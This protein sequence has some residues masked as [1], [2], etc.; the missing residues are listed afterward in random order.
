MC[1]AAAIAGSAVVGA[2]ASA[3]SA[4]KQSKAAKKAAKAAQKQNAQIRDDNTPWREQGQ[5]ALTSIA[6]MMGTS[7]NTSAPNYG[8]FNHQFDANDLKT[9]LAPNYDFMLQQGLGATTNAANAAGFSG[10]AL[11]GINDYVQGYAGNAYQ[12][13]YNNYTNNQTNTYNRLSNLAGLGQTANQTTANAGVGLTGQQI[14][15]QLAGANANAAGIVGGANAVNNGVGNYLGWNYLSKSS[16]YGNVGFGG[17]AAGGS[18]D[19]YWAEGGP[20][21]H[22]AWGGAVP[23]RSMNDWGGAQIN[24]QLYPQ[25]TT[26]ATPEFLAPPRTRV[27]PAP[28][29]DTQ[30]G[31]APSQ[32]GPAI[33]GNSLNSVMNYGGGPAMQPPKQKAPMNPWMGNPRMGFEAGGEVDGPGGPTEDAIPAML[34]DGEHVVAA[35]EVTALGDGNNDLGQR[36]LTHI[37]DMLRRRYA[38]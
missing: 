23:I 18:P 25:Q 11:K 8:F 10:N 3:Y 27:M 14:N 5:K 7:G 34:S 21:R 38:A 37:R 29:M 19:G 16:P 36:R 33:G 35:N 9:S 28:R 2:G 4:N 13:A 20:V 22:Y 32:L 24:A 1:V 12:Q 30:P 15:A 17:N 26:D 6:D 31:Y